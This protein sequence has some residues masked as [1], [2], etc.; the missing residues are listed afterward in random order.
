MSHFSCL[1][2]IPSQ[3]PGASSPSPCFSLHPAGIY[4]W[5]KNRWQEMS[6]A[7]TGT[8]C[9]LFFLFF[10]PLLL[11]FDLS[12]YC[13]QPSITKAWRTS[14][15]G[16]LCVWFLQEHLP[17]SV[18]CLSQSSKLK[19][20]SNN[21]AAHTLIKTVISS[22]FFTRWLSLQPHCPTFSLL[23]FHLLLLPAGQLCVYNCLQ[24]NPKLIANN[25]QWSQK[26]KVAWCNFHIPTDNF[27]KGLISIG[28]GSEP[29]E[30][31]LFPSWYD[32]FCLWQ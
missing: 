26:I 25:T 5:P 14:T 19:F 6:L 23:H 21:S 20:N 27:D 18:C 15:Q 24:S 30:H 3:Y 1:K 7:H 31:S 2:L 13:N 29:D 22:F 28:C 16:P 17:H 12:S 4:W 9:I 11:S 10:S 8:R 32:C